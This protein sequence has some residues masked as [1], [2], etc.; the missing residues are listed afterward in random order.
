MYEAKKKE[1]PY[2]KIGDVVRYFDVDGGQ[3]DGEVLLGKIS[4]VQSV[5]PGQTAD[6]DGDG[7][8]RWLVEINRLEDVGEG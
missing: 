8:D 7:T 5:R 2:P 6:D 3:Q 1:L 4:L